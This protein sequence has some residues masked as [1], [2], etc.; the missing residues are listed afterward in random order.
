MISYFFNDF[1]WF[2]FPKYGRGNSKPLIFTYFNRNHNLAL[3]FGKY[4]LYK[5]K[6]ISLTVHR[7]RNLRQIDV[8]TPTRIVFKSHMLAPY[9]KIER[10]R[11][12]IRLT[13]LCVR[14][15]EFCLFS[16]K[17]ALVSLRRGR[18]RSFFVLANAHHGVLDEGRYCEVLNDVHFR[19]NYCRQHDGWVCTETPYYG[20][21]E[22]NG[23]NV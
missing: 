19:Q 13:H 12:N 17:L 5:R 7:N 9:V 10:T 21:S 15:F 16:Q 23:W 4:I 14:L 3:I 2:F 11:Q 18:S 22:F 1:N 20:S 8:Q 6:N